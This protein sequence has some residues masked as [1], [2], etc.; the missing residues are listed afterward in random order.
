MCIFSNSSFVL[1]HSFFLKEVDKQQMA[2]WSNLNWL[3][4]IED[5]H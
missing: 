4:S 1:L 3:L 5:L 2:L